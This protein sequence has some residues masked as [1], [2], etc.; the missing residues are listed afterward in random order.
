[1][2]QICK[3]KF[4]SLFPEEKTEKVFLLFRFSGHRDFHQ[5]RI[6]S[7]PPRKFIAIIL[8]Q[9]FSGLQSHATKGRGE[10]NAIVSA[11]LLPI[12]AARKPE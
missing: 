9:F 11:G 5:N 6:G 8:L 4:L 12:E 1:M 3:K 10:M 7:G 2:R